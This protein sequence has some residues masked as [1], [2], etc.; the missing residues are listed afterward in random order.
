MCRMAALCAR[1]ASTRHTHTYPQALTEQ[2]THEND[3]SGSARRLQISNQLEEQ[4]NLNLSLCAH[5]F[6]SALACHWFFAIFVEQYNA[7]ASAPPK[8]KEI[9]LVPPCVCVCGGGGGLGTVSQ[10]L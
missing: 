7:S 2:P 5:C 8:T 1:C 3:I 4:M 9:V 6:T 10:L